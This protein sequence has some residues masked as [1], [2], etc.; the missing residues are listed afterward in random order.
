MIPR[1]ESFLPLDLAQSAVMTREQ[2]ALA[3]KG[4]C[5]K[6]SAQSLTAGDRAEGMRFRHCR[7]CSSMYVLSE[8]RPCA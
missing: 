3:A 6:C 8:V 1:R 2:E 5:F 7:L 4:W